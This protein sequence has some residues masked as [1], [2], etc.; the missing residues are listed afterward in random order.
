MYQGRKIH[1]DGLCKQVLRRVDGLAVCEVWSDHAGIPSAKSRR[2]AS[3][4]KC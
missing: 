1:G 2:D 3:D 4:V